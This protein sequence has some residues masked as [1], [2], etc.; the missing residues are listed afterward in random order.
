MMGLVLAP[1]FLQLFICW[2]LVGLCS[3]LLIGYWY[4]GRRRRARR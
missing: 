1:N 2:E 3:Y 4:T